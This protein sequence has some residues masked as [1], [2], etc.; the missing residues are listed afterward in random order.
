LE[1]VR[2]VRDH[3]LDVAV[4]MMPV[5]PYLTDTRAHLDHGLAQI[6]E[7]GGTSVAYSALHLR[8][9]A[10][11]W[12]LQWLERE[13]PD[14]VAKY[15]QL[16]SK[17]AYAPKAYRAWLAERMRPLLR[18]HGLERPRSAAPARAEARS[19]EQS[20]IAQELPLAF[21]QPRLF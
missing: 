3:G 7:A 10:R 4:F 14:L 21:P 6:R 15:A 9:G 8:P 20:L 16:Y 5:L 2:A 12:Y 18:R 17:G 11:E 1:T 19:R 13:H